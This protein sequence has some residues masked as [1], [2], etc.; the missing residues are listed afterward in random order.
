MQ[1]G[2]DPHFVTQTAVFEAIW[3]YVRAFR[4]SE[5]PLSIDDLDCFKTR[6]LA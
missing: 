2:T 4:D 1:Q 6:R 3:D 5:I